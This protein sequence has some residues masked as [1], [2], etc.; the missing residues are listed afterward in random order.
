MMT[1]LHF[2][3]TIG[4]C[5]TVLACDDSQS[6][7][8][9]PLDMSTNSMADTGHQPMD[10]GVGSQD[11]GTGQTDMDL[12]PTLIPA[13]V[14]VELRPRR[15]IYRRSDRPAIEYVVYDRIGRIIADAPV[16]L[17][18]QPMGQAEIGED[19]TIT[20]LLEGAG[21]VRACATPDLCGRASFYVDDAAPSLE[22][23][24]P[25][26]AA[27][28]TGDPSIRVRGRTDTDPG[29]R[30][31]INDRPVMVDEMGEFETEL[32]AEFGLNRIDV[33]A[34]DGVRRP[35]TRSVREVL[36]APTVIP[37]DDAEI[38]LDRVAI[39]RFHQAV[40]DRQEAPDPPGPDGVQRVPDLAGTAE[41]LLSRSNLMMLLDNPQIADDDDFS[42]RI[43]NVDQ[44]TPDVTILLTDTGFEIFIRL[45]D[46]AFDTEGFIDVAG[47][48]FSLVGRVLLTVAGFASAEMRI[49]DQGIPGLIVDDFGLA[50]ESLSGE[51]NDSTA[52]AV[53][54]T[55]GSIA[56]RVLN[57]A[58]D[59]L[60]RDL[61]A[62]ELPNFIELGLDDV[63]EP[64]RDISLNLSPD[65]PL[66]G[67]EL[68]LSLNAQE[69]IFARRD[70]LELIL[71]GTVRQ[72]MAVQAPHPH[73]GIPDFPPEA[74]PV[75][76]PNRGIS[77][78]IRLSLFNSVLSSA[79]HQ[80]AFSIDLSEIVPDGF[81]QISGLT[82][83][84]RIPPVIVPAQPG[85][86]NLMELQFG[87]ID[88]FVQN[89]LNA[90]PDHYVMSLRAGVG[91]EFA[92]GE[93][94]GIVDEVPDV[95]FELLSEGGEF[96][97]LDPALFSALL[98]AQIGPELNEAVA[99]LLT[100]DLDGIVVEADAFSPLNSDIE[101]I[102]IQP[103]FPSPPR[104]QNGWLI[105]EATAV[106]EIR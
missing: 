95:R 90:S 84:A 92:A 10:L 61:V 69:P 106:T 64:L 37:A 23:I 45:E 87:E 1:R 82:M 94:E 76:P 17:D 78:A 72:P 100:V 68:N 40:I 3:I 41:A 19:E 4:L 77:M 2:I 6:I 54:D 98:Q 36:W 44:G 93:I 81:P 5:L 97:A 66:A 91:L 85:S 38:A 80:G 7:G 55:V 65:P 62:D 105:I 18:I 11:V 75:W 12:T 71:G 46:L 21:A 60:V 13:Y 50:V 9:A 73:P 25:T 56:R 39:M 101:T 102:T 43:T 74:D 15:G 28:L 58:A 20:F 29:I 48:S 96:P 32:R 47:E 99:E 22:I 83:D 89:P 8:S 53:V 104:I 14:D 70:R 26:R 103:T 51:F 49:D 31:F 86:P 42:M 34:D 88:L 63:I 59:E 52:Q 24:E 30:V 67:I 27:I 57:S 35:A 79:W 33:I 16:R